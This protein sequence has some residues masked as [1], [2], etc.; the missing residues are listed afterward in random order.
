M[1]NET[2]NYQPPNKQMGLPAEYSSQLFNNMQGIN[3][4][5]VAASRQSIL[6][7]SRNPAMAGVQQMLLRQN[8]QQGADRMMEQGT[9]AQLQGV[10][11]GLTD[12]RQQQTRDFT[13]SESAAERANRIALMNL[14]NQ[15]SMNLQQQGQQN[16]SATFGRQLLSGG[17]MA[18]GG[19]MGGPVFGAI[20]GQLANQIA[21]P[22]TTTKKK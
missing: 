15:G 8:Q 21:A 4:G 20:G 2:L 9:A 18:A 13:A 22:P 6:D 17:L 12:R 3:K 1:I 7:S 11:E 10:Q 5:Q 16:E 19:M 14:Q